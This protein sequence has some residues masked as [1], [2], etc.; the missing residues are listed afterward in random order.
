MNGYEQVKA[1]IRGI[2]KCCE[3][4]NIVLNKLEEAAQKDFGIA[5]LLPTTTAGMQ[6]L[7]ESCRKSTICNCFNNYTVRA[8]KCGKYVKRRDEYVKRRDAQPTE[9]TKELDSIYSNKNNQPTHM[10]K[11][12]KLQRRAIEGIFT[13]RRC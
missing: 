3:E 12:K 7:C 9:T 5:A 2:K 10:M 6:C 13:L 8:V 4:L 1:S 11:L